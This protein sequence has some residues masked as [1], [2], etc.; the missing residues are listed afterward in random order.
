[1]E[2]NEDDDDILS[3]VRDWQKENAPLPLGAFMSEIGNEIESLRE[4]NFVLRSA[5]GEENRAN[6]MTELYKSAKQQVEELVRK[7]QDLRAYA[8]QD[9]CIADNLRSEL[10][11][12]RWKLGHVIY[13]PA[14]K[15]CHIC[16]E[17]E[18]EICCP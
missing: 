4:Q 1:M 12:M 8:E 2:M 14:K 16:T 3:R 17:I 5:V 7:N 10:K 9:S 15:T 18:R 13:C 11:D 6:R